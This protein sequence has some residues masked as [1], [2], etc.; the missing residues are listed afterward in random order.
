MLSVPSFIL[1]AERGANLSLFGWRLIPQPP[2]INDKLISYGIV[3]FYLSVWLKIFL[4]WLSP[5]KMR[6]T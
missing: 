2:F 4:L 6:V 5:P 1:L 3:I